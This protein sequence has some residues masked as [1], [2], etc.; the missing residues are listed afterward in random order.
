MNTTAIKAAICRPQNYCSL[1]KTAFFHSTPVLER[2]RHSSSS[3]DGLFST[4]VGLLRS[5]YQ[6]LDFEGR[7]KMINRVCI[8]VMNTYSDFFRVLNIWQKSNAHKKKRSK[9]FLKEHQEAVRRA[10]EE[11]K[12]ERE[13]VHE[14]YD[15]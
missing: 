8:V 2:K 7:L 3:S 9:K 13:E 5:I 14:N 6:S 10:V 12:Q 11:L 4:C 1:L 15:V